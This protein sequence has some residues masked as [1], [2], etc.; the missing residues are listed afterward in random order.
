MPTVQEFGRNLEEATASLRSLHGLVVANSGQIEEHNGAL[1][2]FAVEWHATAEAVG[3]QSE[4]LAALQQEQTAALT[5]EWEET[6]G[7]IE[8]SVAK[9]ED[10]EARVAGHKGSILGLFGTV[11]AALDQIQSAREAKHGEVQA[12]AEEFLEELGS[13]REMLDTAHQTEVTEFTSFEEHTGEM[14]ERL[15]QHRAE[16]DDVHG[17]AHSDIGTTHL[18]RVHQEASDHFAEVSGTMSETLTS[19]FSEL[20]GNFEQIHQ[21]FD[22]T[23]VHL[24]EDL[25]N[26][27]TESAERLGQHIETEA[28]DKL[29]EAIET[30]VRECVEAFMAEIIENITMMS[31]GASVTASMTPV[32]P[33]LIAAKA[34]ISAIN[35]ILEALK[36]ANPFD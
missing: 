20:T 11:T 27:F 36:A 3:T 16:M 28:R 4:A 31:V 1:E 12:G 23:V 21:T 33:M 10:V 9:A 15:H 7:L 24:V 14:Q 29:T 25:V 17:T 13:L 8:S 5:R 30:C 32:L 6:K 19:Q 18:E 35:D 2:E 22:A 34:L 26:R